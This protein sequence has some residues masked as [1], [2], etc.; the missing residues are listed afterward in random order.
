M[1]LALLNSPFLKGSTASSQE[2]FSSPFKILRLADSPPLVYDYF[3]FQKEELRYKVPVHRT[4]NK[5]FIQKNDPARSNSCWV[6][7]WLLSHE[8]AAI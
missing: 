8:L 2:G 3:A 6:G 1:H 5:G 4:K 7:S